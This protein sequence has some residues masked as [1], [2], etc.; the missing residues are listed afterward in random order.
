M[1]G[2]TSRHTPGHSRTGSSKGTNDMAKKPSR[3]KPPLMY[4]PPRPG[5]PAKS[6]AAAHPGKTRISMTKSKK[7]VMGPQP[8]G[9]KPKMGP[10]APPKRKPKPSNPYAR[11]TAA[12]SDQAT[13]AYDQEVSFRKKQTAKAKAKP[14]SVI[15]GIT[16]SKP[17]SRQQQKS[18]QTKRR[19]DAVAKRQAAVKTGAASRKKKTFGASGTRR[20]TPG[21]QSTR[22]RGSR[23]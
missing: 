19:A 15:N 9:R 8:S 4:Q 5:G 22:G 7:P 6:P 1:P 17:S 16:Q 13:R 3:T 11:E 21:D 23:R 2:F 18:A 10:P 20:T 14:S 12:Q